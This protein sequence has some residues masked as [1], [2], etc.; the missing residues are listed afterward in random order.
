LVFPHATERTRRRK[1]KGGL[2]TAVNPPINEALFADALIASSGERSSRRCGPQRHPRRGAPLRRMLARGRKVVYCGRRF[3]RPC[4]SCAGTRRASRELFGLDEK[5][6]RDV[7]SRGTPN[8][9][10]RRLAEE[11]AP[12]AGRQAIGALAILQRSRGRRFGPAAPPLH[13]RSRSGGAPSRSFVIAIAH[14]PGSPLRPGPSADLSIA[15]EET[16]RGSHGM[17]A[18]TA[19]RPALGMLRQLGGSNSA[20]HIAA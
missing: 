9:P 1:R 15:A 13:R 12:E 3:V 17:A 11:T 2:T 18:G 5:P 4:C 8:I 16:L 10:D 19:Q 14:R 20:T 7:L 6:H